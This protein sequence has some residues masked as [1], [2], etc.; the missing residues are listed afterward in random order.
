M[1]L[2]DVCDLLNGQQLFFII[3]LATSLTFRDN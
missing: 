1:H 3:H 2:H